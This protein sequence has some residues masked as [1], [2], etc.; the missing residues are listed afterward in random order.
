MWSA[1]R[2]WIKPEHLPAYL[3]QKP[4][5][6]QA[7]ESRNSKIAAEEPEKIRLQKA[8]DQA[9]GKKSEAAQALGI[10]RVTLWKKMKKFNLSP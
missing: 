2:K 5:R 1:R 7:L 9:G 8:L 4:G 6:F 3:N 10:S